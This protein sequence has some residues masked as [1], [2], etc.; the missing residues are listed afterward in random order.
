M[1]HSNVIPTRN[2]PERLATCLSSIMEARNSSWEYEVLVMDN[3]DYHVRA[4]NAHV[5]ESCADSRF[6]YLPMTEVG[7][8]AARHQGVE[9]AGAAIVSF[10]DD[11]ELVLPGWFEGVRSCLRDSEV[12]LAT[13]PFV[14]RFEAK[15]PSWLEYL[16]QTDRNGRH[17]G[18][19]TL[20]DAGDVERDIEPRMVWGGNLTVR[21][22]VFAEV[23]GSHPDYIPS[24]WEAF[25]GDGEVGLTV[26]VGAAGYRA[27][28]SPDCAVLHE[29]PAER[30]TLEYLCRR[31]WFVGLH[32]SFTQARREHGMGADRG[33]PVA[34]VMLRQPFLR[35]AAGRV[36]RVA[37]ARLA[38]VIVPTRPATAAEQTAAGVRRQL[39]DAHREGYLWHREKLESVPGLRA[40]VCR[41]DF[42][43]E[44]A[45]LPLEAAQD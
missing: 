22:R 14:P 42:L 35:R 15:P 26:K 6:R 36:R 34:S 20:L 9:A 33:V 11:D 30:M 12:A 2:H 23:R 44:N 4:A 31:A 21:K 27:R 18:Y 17:M 37:S 45:A 16:W 3:S 39:A 40:Y 43:G 25:Q 5:V 28:Y 19:L 10:V 24:P 38:R 1:D 7:L 29:V 13:G 41:P 32:T 8:M